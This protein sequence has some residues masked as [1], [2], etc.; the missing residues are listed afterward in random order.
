MRDLPDIPVQ[1]SGGGIRG[2]DQGSLGP[3]GELQRRSEIVGSAARLQFVQHIVVGVRQRGAELLSERHARSVDD[4][5]RAADVAGSALE[6]VGRFDALH[7][8]L[9]PFPHR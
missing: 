3:I 9:I 6:P 1:K 7:G 4:L 8:V 5:E 2:D